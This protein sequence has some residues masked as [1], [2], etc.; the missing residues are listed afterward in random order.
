M[1]VASLVV[2]LAGCGFDIA[3]EQPLSPPAVY[4]E[5][6]ARTEVEP[7]LLLCFFCYTKE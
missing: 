2:L 5:W 7:R 1:A 3:G 6:W 4:R